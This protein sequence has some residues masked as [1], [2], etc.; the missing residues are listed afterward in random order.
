MPEDLGNLSALQ[1]ETAGRFCASPGLPSLAD[2][3]PDRLND[4]LDSLC[5]R[6]TEGDADALS[7]QENF[8]D[9]FSLVRSVRVF[10]AFSCRRVGGAV[11]S[12]Y[13]SV[14]FVCVL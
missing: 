5:A 9:L 11:R 13:G 8:D 3:T 10:C 7:Q 14:P 4:L 2:E 1:V 12:R 6:L